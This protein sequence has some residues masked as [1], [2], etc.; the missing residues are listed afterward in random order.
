MSGFFEE[1]KRRKVYRVAVAYVV[2]AGG[3]IQLASAAFPAWE[4]PNWAL[5][6]VIVLLL[7]GFPIAL[8]LAWAFDV[9]PQ[10]IRTTPRAES[11]QPTH[12]RRNL[13]LLSTAGLV[14]SAV[15]GFFLLPHASARKMDKSI[16]VLPFENFSD[17]KENA[18][19]ADG[20]QD[21]VLTSLSKVGDLKVIS[22]TSV[23]SYR[24]KEKNVR[25]IGKALGV[26][27]ILEGSVRKSGNRVRVNVQLINAANDE[28]IWAEDYD[29]ELTDVFAIQS[30]LAHEITEVLRAKLSPDEKLVMERK[31]TQNNEAYLLYLQVRSLESSGEES[32]ELLKKAEQLLE[33]AT[34]L[35]PQFALA[36]AE[37][38]RAESYIYHGPDPTVARINKA[39]AAAAE[40]LRLQPDLPEGHLALGN[41]YYYGDR[42]YE[43]ALQEY[44][45]AQRGL[46][47]DSRVFMAIGAI[48]RRQG[49]WTDSIANM[50]KAAV[51]DPR[52][53]SNLKELAETYVG[54]RDYSTAAELIDRAIALAPNFYPLKI[55]RATLDLDWKGDP[56]ALNKMLAAAPPDPALQSELVVPKAI[57]QVFHKNY[58]EAARIIRE[59][60]QDQIEI[61]F[62]ISAP[63]EFVLGRIYFVAKNYEEAKRQFEAARPAIEA[64]VAQSP[65]AAARH[66][67]LGEVYAGIGRKDDAI[68]EGK[69]AVE[70]L[71]ESIDAFQGPQIAA[72]LAAIYAMFGDADDAVPLIEHLLTGKVGISVHR[73]EE[74]DWDGI[75][76]DPRFQALIKKYGGKT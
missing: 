20:I 24:G 46:P 75:R 39:R 35:D 48:Q 6:L 13:I 2:V 47:N 25:E 55:Q 9:T 61:D 14:V 1:I 54:L 62:G 38:G 8:I 23:T 16:A 10:G 65:F 12:R 73:L 17:D 4:L 29:R 41:C 18:Y 52:N 66:G 3:L 26:A 51:L 22:R 72:Q 36:F 11:S 49:K 59:S 42:D 74:P 69:R 21:D 31:P 53:P 67:L 45:I 40:A 5:R 43:R 68:R 33:R 70:L 15:A 19:F 7:I 44:A 71:P 50:K 63:K 37:L 76:G 34:Q 60:A 27:A 56:T 58:E 30:E 57:A 28:H 64:S 32:F